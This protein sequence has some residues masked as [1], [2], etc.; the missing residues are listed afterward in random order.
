ML[1]IQAKKTIINSVPSTVTLDNVTFQLQKSFGKAALNRLISP[2]V[3]ISI[4]SEGKRF[5]RSIDDCIEITDTTVSGSDL[6]T[7][8]LQYTVGASFQKRTASDT[9]RKTNSSLYPLHHTPVT[10]ITSVGSYVKGT[11]FVLENDHETLHWLK[12]G[13]AVDTNFTVSYEYLEDG[14]WISFGIADFLMQG[15]FSNLSNL[16][17]KYNVSVVDVGDVIDLSDIYTNQSLSVCAFDVQL[18]YPYKWSR[19]ATEEDGVLLE[20]IDADL[21]VNEKFIETIHAP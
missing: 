4:I 18:V 17:N 6:R 16:L 19:T 20:S 3:N 11:D 7:A 14:Y 2:S 21:F 9:I 5:S 12:Q 8:I 15:C 10:D 13:P 1:P